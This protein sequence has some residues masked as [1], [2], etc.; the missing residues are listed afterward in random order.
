MSKDERNFLMKVK[1]VSDLSARSIARKSLIT[2]ADA[3]TLLGCDL[4]KTDL[5]WLA[6]VYHSYSLKPSSDGLCAVIE[7]TQLH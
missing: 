5:E 6:S 7:R 1:S 3:L 4:T 2:P